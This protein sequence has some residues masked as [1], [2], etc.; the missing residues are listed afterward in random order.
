MYKKGELIQHN[1]VK[2]V[3]MRVTEDVPEGGKQVHGRDIASGNLLTCH[4]DNV[5]KLG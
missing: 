4:V 1:N 5:T 2:S 3:L